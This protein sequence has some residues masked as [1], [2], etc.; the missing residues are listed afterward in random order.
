MGNLSENFSNE[1]FKCRCPFCQGKEYR[2]HL[3]LVGGV[4]AIAVHFGKKV[5][6]LAGFWCD[7][8]Y[9]S[10]KRD[11]RSYHVKGKAAH[12]RIDG[13]PLNALF[14]FAETVPDFNGLGFYPK[15]NFIHVDTRPQEK[16]DSW[17][18][19]GSTYSPL[20]QDKRRQYDL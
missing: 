11:R 4:E 20:T 1:D 10:L 5:S 15:E 2:I 6:V 16:K 18:K 8:Y 9:D 3:G 7:D 17:V 19:E 13:V 12:I 14:R